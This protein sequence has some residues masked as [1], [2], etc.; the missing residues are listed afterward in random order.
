MALWKEYIFWTWVQ[1]LTLF[2]SSSVTLGKLFNLFEP[3][4]PQLLNDLVIPTSSDCCE[5]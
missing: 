2:C 4:F 5:I 3:Q 1:F